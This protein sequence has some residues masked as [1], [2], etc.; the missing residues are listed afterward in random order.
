MGP[1]S[2]RRRARRARARPGKTLG[3]ERP[4]TLIVSDDPTKTYGEGQM[5][6]WPTLDEAARAFLRSPAPYKAIVFDDDHEAR[7]LN[8]AEQAGVR[9][10]CAVAGYS[11]EEI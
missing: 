7:E 2:L 1:L 9:C 4:Y 8:A 5:S 11:I 6:D 3:E 10:V